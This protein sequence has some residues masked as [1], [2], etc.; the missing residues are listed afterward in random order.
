MATII[1]Q[2]APQRSTQYTNLARD[3]VE[4]ELLAS[5]LGRDISEVAMETIAGQHYVKFELPG[6]VLS[7]HHALHLAGMAMIGGLFELFEKIDGVPGPLLRP[8]PAIYR[9]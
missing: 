7:D 9:Y 1:A 4:I 3:L 2:V 5:P 8:I 6:A